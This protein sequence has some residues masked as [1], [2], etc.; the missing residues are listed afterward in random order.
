MPG[1]EHLHLLQAEVSLQAG[2]DIVELILLH[3]QVRLN[4]HVVTLLVK[5]AT[6]LVTI[7]TTP[8]I[9]IE[10]AAPHDPSKVLAWL[11]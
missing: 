6:S 1:D 7:A 10:N 8:T 4:W 5:I 2:N 9:V 3:H 11:L